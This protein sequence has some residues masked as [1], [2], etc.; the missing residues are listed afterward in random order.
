M[1]SSPMPVASLKNQPPF[2]PGQGN[3]QLDWHSV[4]REDLGDLYEGLLEKN[5]NEKK[6]GVGQ[7][8]TLRQLI[9]SMV[10]VM[11]PSLDD[12]IQ[13]PA[14]ET[15]EFLIAANYAEQNS[16]NAYAASKSMA[17]SFTGKNRRALISS[18][19]TA[20]LQI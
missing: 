6:S 20:P 14:A 10:R 4:H 11:K 12:I 8:L 17:G 9:N 15:G 18:I 7:Y 13:D 19:F 3:H 1:K 5:A 2:Q 16:G